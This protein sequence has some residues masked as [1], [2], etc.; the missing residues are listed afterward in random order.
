[1]TVCRAETCEDEVMLAGRPRPLFAV[2]VWPGYLNQVGI[3]SANFVVGEHQY[4]HIDRDMALVERTFDPSTRRPPS[5]R[6]W[7][8][9]CPF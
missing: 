2:C 7:L 4:A 8:Q 9:N 3:V 1:V 5:R 6:L